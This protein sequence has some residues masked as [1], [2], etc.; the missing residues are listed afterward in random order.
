MGNPNPQVQQGL[1]L[2]DLALKHRGLQIFQQQRPW[3]ER[4]ATYFLLGKEGR[5]TNIVLNDSFLSD[6]PATDEY[7]TSLDRYSLAVAGRAQFGSPELFFCESGHAISVEM[8]WPVEVGQPMKAG[9]GWIPVTVTDAANSQSA[10]CGVE[11]ATGVFGPTTFDMVRYIANRVR[12]SVDNRKIVFFDGEARQDT[13]Q[14]LH[15]ETS[16]QGHDDSESQTEVKRT[17]SFL[18]GKAYTLGFYFDG[19]HKNVWIA[20]PWDADYLGIST[21][22]LLV[23]AA[24]LSAQGLLARGAIDDSMRPTDKLIAA[25]WPPAEEIAARSQGQRNLR[26]SELPSK[27]DFNR[28]L[29]AL[30]TDRAEAALILIDL[31]HFKEV[32]DT[33]G[34]LAGDDCLQ[35]AVDAILKAV[36]RKGTLYRW[37]GDEFAVLLPDYSTGEALATA[38]RIRREVE[39]SKAGGEIAVTASIGVIATDHLSE[40]SAEE[41]LQAADEAMYCSKK[42]GRNRVTSGP[43]SN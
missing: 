2:F 11:V 27:N 25:G 3:P 14:N 38:E 26:F 20:D 1:T 23:A 21:K 16:D 4:R 18:A 40:S 36:G 19:K 28:D 43:A 33:H 9:R 30:R 24:V 5:R 39:S 34:H 6:L 35:R 37:G 13:Y 15:F 17:Q 41:F 8:A 10:R 31:D 22:D 42:Q 12:R 32:N 7:K 29:A